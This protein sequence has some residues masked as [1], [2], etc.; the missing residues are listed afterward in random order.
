MYLFLALETEPCSNL[1]CFIMSIKEKE[2]PSV[3]SKRILGEQISSY[4][5]KD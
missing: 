2:F 3:T 1:K 4:C 5:I